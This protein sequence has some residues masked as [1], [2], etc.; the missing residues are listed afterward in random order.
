MKLDINAVGDISLGDHPVCAG[1]GMRS[2]FEREGMNVFRAV[3]PEIKNADINL[4]N[5]ETV[6]SNIGF[7]RFWLPSFEMRGDPA[8]LSTVK[9]FGFNVFGVANNHAMQHGKEAFEDMVARISKT[10]ASLIGIDLGEGR[11]AVREFEHES[12]ETSA[13]FAVSIRPEEWTKD[14]PVPYS[15]RES[16]DSLLREVS[17]LRQRYSGFLV[18]SIHWGLEFLDYPAPGQIELGRRLLDA[19]VDVVFGHHPHVLQPVESYKNGLIFYSLGNFVFDLWPESTKLTAIA[20]V[21][22]EKGLLPEYEI[23]PVKICSDLKLRRPADT[24]SK[25]ILEMM[26][27]RHFESLKNVPKTDLEYES[28]YKK[29]RMDFRYSSYRYFLSNIPKYP[30]RFL[31]HSLARTGIRRLL[32]R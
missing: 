12:G 11:T 29:A 8:Q 13:I 25:K 28:L 23:V 30:F 10:G 32:G 2:V 9:N 6:A 7:S 3:A 16:T 21:R 14:R 4:C 24:D 22:L 18:C 5:I 26:S 27:W 19:G 15:L 20:K 1:H 31:V 17:E